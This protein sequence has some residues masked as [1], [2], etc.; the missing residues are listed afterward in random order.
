MNS[1]VLIAKIWDIPIRLHL[2]WFI[3]FFLVAWSL[4]IGYFP[5]E[6]PQLSAPVYWLLGAFTSLLFGA[7]VLA[8]ELGHSFVALR[9]K[10]PVRSVTLFIFGGIAQI[11]QEPKTPKA[12]FWIAIAGPL[13]S[14]ALGLFF[15]ALWLLDRQIPV[16]S[17]PSVW[18]A[19]I[20]LVLAFFNLIP[21]FPLDGGRVLRSIVWRFNNDL[22]KATRIAATAGQ[23]VAFG[24]IA[25]GVYTIFTGNFFNGLWLA[26]IGWFLQNAAASAISQSTIQESLRGVPVSQVMLRNL[27][28]IPWHTKLD[29]VVEEQVIPFGSRIFLVTDNSGTALRGMLTLRSVTAVP[30]ER[31]PELSAEDVMIPRADF[32]AVQPDMELIDAM[33]IMDDAKVNQVPVMENDEVIGILSREEVVHYIRLRSEIG[34]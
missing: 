8:H 23:V 13:T 10:V 2:S 15:G 12:E 30:R 22:K 25:F 3:I 19:R 1:G 7:S 31:W 17:A 26:F 33:R 5:Q 16:L 11:E 24:F 28:S 4:A 9:Y 29:C 27:R 14:L 20:N 18:L 32:V 34:F 21:G 6:Y